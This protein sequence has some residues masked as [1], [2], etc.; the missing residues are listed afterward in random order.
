MVRRIGVACVAVVVL[1]SLATPALAVDE[2]DPDWTGQADRVEVRQA[3]P[4]GVVLVIDLPSS[5]I[6][7]TEPTVGTLPLPAQA[8][9][10][11]S[12]E[13][14]NVTVEPNQLCRDAGGLVGEHWDADVF[15]QDGTPLDTL[16]ETDPDTEPGVDPGLGEEDATTAAEWVVEQLRYNRDQLASILA[17]QTVP[18]PARGWLES[19]Q[20]EL[21]FVDDRWERTKD[22]VDED[23]PLPVD[24]I[25]AAEEAIE[26][27]RE[28]LGDEEPA[29]RVAEVEAA[30]EEVLTRVG[31]E[32]GEEPAPIG[33]GA[34]DSALERLD[35][36]GD[37]DGGDDEGGEDVAVPQ[38][39]LLG[40][41]SVELELEDAA[42]AADPSVVDEHLAEA[43]TL[44]EQALR[45][46]EPVE[47][48]LAWHTSSPLFDHARQEA[49]PATSALASL[50][51]AIEAAQ[52]E[53]TASA[54]DEAQAYR[55]LAEDELA[56]LGE[57]IDAGTN[58]AP[59]QVR[60]FLP[61]SGVSLD[62]PD[63]GSTVDGS[64]DGGS[65][66][67]SDDELLD[68]GSPTEDPDADPST[69]GEDDGL[70]GDTAD[71]EQACR[72]LDDSDEESSDD[73]GG[74]DGTD[75]GDEDGSA[76]DSDDG[77]QDDTDGGTDDGSNE[78]DGQADEGSDQ[79][80]T[81]GPS[82]ELSVDTER[83]RTGG[84]EQRSLTAT[85][86]NPSDETHG[87]QLVA[88]DEEPF[89]VTTQG[90]AEA[91]LGPGEEEQFPL[92]IAPTDEGEAELTVRA[93]ADDGRQAEEQIPVEVVA[94]EENLR[95]GMP[96]SSVE[97][98]T[99][100]TRT[101]DVEVENTGPY[102]DEVTL[103]AE[104]PDELD[105]SVDGPTSMPL[106]AGDRETVAVTLSAEETGES[107]LDVTV[108]AHDGSTVGSVV[109]V[110]A[111]EDQAEE[112]EPASEDGSSQGEA[113]DGGDEPEAQ[114]VPVGLAS[115]LA[116]IA[117]AARRGQG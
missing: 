90:E 11:V 108:E 71:P 97:L 29:D 70:V 18:E 51:E 80:G 56:K 93:I 44:A 111:G 106:A 31:D 4:A 68:D 38:T 52:E 83:I 77:S 110:D 61:A 36:S 50:V 115:L 7:R 34:V 25:E 54:I 94:N 104:G 75:G 9:E 64:E 2:P 84:A 89:S 22:T 63:T 100:E 19:A 39:G 95:V 35:G 73:Q 113:S 69:T 59:D 85:I 12:A 88:D 74:D 53:P 91:E 98:A 6:D 17:D 48:E 66:G 81:G 58:D 13:Q 87:Y 49:S 96:A 55:V 28:D 117:A 1:V 20:G 65:D 46:I 86:A 67:G 33:E 76:D 72:D 105:A 16:P 5:A 107:A 47:E 112:A 57:E 109:L 60:V 14:L 3:S 103:A 92:R 82:V 116:A 79:D 43:R 42:G 45:T 15:L 24:Q 78:D 32:T 30:L 101:L 114:T 23:T 27:A 40:S 26:Q 21:A 99:D 37:E 10:V 102:D 62:A 41:S 8:Q